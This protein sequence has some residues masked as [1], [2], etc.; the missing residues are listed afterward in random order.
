MNKTDL[1][2][3]RLKRRLRLSVFLRKNGLFVVIAVCLL[4][5][6]GAVIL[7]SG[8][9]GRPSAPAERKDDET[10]KE[11]EARN[12]PAPYH[13]SPPVKPLAPTDRPE[14]TPLPTLVPDMTPAPTVTPAPENR[15][16]WVSPVDGR[17]LR[18]YAMD[19]LIYSKTLGQWMTHP[20]VDI[21]APKGAEVR[22]VAEGTVKRVYDDDMLGTTVIVIHDGGFETVY[23]NLQKNPPVKEGDRIAARG[24][25][26]LV[27]NTAISECT[28][29]SHLHFEIRKDG[30]PV[31]PSDYIVFKHE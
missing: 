29:D 26:G 9:S 31:D 12:T 14:H 2:R 15:N 21:S 27:G 5:I 4:A 19:C 30:V 6:G 24:L 8:G 1:H 17:L 18:G 13:T 23:S 25:I 16:K 22:A 7:M 10:L 11:A 3:K 20:G 28:E